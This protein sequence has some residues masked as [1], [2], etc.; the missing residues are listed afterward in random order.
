MKSQLQDLK[1][2]L[3]KK[4]MAIYEGTRIEVHNPNVFEIKDGQMTSQFLDCLLIIADKRMYCDSA[5]KAV[6]ELMAEEGVAVYTDGH[7]RY[8]T[9]DGTRYRYIEVETSYD[10]PLRTTVYVD[11][12][13]H[14]YVVESNGKLHLHRRDNGDMNGELTR[15]PVQKLKRRTSYVHQA[16]EKITDKWLAKYPR[17]GE[18]MTGLPEKHLFVET[19]EN[20]L[21][22]SDYLAD[23]TEKILQE[24][25]A[26]G[27]G[28]V[29]GN[30]MHQ[31][32]WPND[33]PH[34]NRYFTTCRIAEPPD[35][36]MRTFRRTFLPHLVSIDVQARPCYM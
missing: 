30:F 26:R 12:M 19:A 5:D 2:R 31:D 9:Y 34:N 4:L 25:E 15:L 27:D 16:A 18:L 7:G 23:I 8:Y 24:L 17:L 13:D 21:C 36:Q 6:A 11:A 10:L 35:K 1:E 28:V 14:H 20:C 29:Y 32:A 33:Y 3:E 22:D